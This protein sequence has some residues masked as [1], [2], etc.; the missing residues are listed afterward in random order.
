MRNRFLI[1]VPTLSFLFAQPSFSSI[2]IATNADR[3]A[4]VYAID[5]D[6]DGDIDVLMAATADNEIAWYENNGSE[7][8]TKHSITTS[9]TEARD[10][11]AIDLDRD[12]DMD[13]LSASQGSNAGIAWYENNGSESFTKRNITVNTEYAQ[14]VFAIDLDSDGDIDVLSA[15]ITDDKIEW[16]KNNGSQSFEALTITTNADGAYSVYAADVDSDGDMDVLSASVVDDEIAWYKNDG[17]EAFTKHTITDQADVPRSVYAID[18]DQDGD[19]DVL[20]ASEDDNKIA[21]YENNGSQSFTSHTISSSYEDPYDVIALDLDQDGD[22]D[23]LSANYSGAN[24]VWFEN[25]GSESFTPHVINA[26]VGSD[27]QSIFAAD[28]NQD[29]QIDVLSTQA[30][31]DKVSWHKNTAAPFGKP[32]FQ[33]KQFYANNNIKKS[34]AIDMDKDG[35]IDI[36]TADYV[37]DKVSWHQNDGSENFTDYTVA[38][39]ID[40]AND[41]IALD[42][43]QDGDMDIISSSFTDD[44]VR[45]YENNGSQDFTS[46][47]VVNNA[48]GVKAIATGDLDQDGDIDL[49]SVSAYD[50]Q[51]SWYENTDNFMTPNKRS[52]ANSSQVDYPT[53]VFLADMDIDGDLDILIASHEKAE[54]LWIENKGLQ[55]NG[56]LNTAYHSIYNSFTNVSSAKAIDLDLDGDMDVVGISYQKLIWFENNGFMSFTSR[57]ITSLSGN[58]AFFDLA[59]ID[60]DGFIDIMTGDWAGSLMWFKNDGS[61]N[62]SSEWS[63]SVGNLYDVFL[64]DLD[65]DGDIDIIPSNNSSPANWY[66]SNPDRDSPTISSVS[67]ASDNSTVS[68]TMDEAVFRTTGGSGDLEAGDF[69]LSIAG[70]VATVAAVP[71]GISIS[72]NVST[73]E[74]DLTGTPNGSEVLTVNPVD[75]GIYDANGNEASTTQSNNTVTLNDQ[76]VP[77]ISSV[78][79]ASDNSTVSVTMSEAVFNTTGGSGTLEVSDFAFSLRGGTATLSSA[80]PTSISVRG[81]T[82]FTLGISFSGTPNGTDTLT[83]TPVDNNS[84]YDATGNGAITTQSNNLGILNVIGQ[85]TGNDLSV[86]ASKI[87]ISKLE[88]SNTGTITDL[89]I[90]LTIDMSDNSAFQ[91]M[92]VSLLSPTGT[93]VKLLKYGTLSSDTY[94]TKLDDEASQSITEAQTPYSGRYRPINPISNFYNET[95]KGTWELV[96]A[97][98]QSHTGTI[99]WVLDFAT[100]T[101]TPLSILNYGTE[102]QGEQLAIAANGN[103]TKSLSISD[104]IIITDLNIKLT[105]NMSDNTAYQY[106]RVLLKS[107]KISFYPFIESQFENDLYKTIIDDEAVKVRASSDDWF[108]PYIGPHQSPYDTLSRFNGTSTS[109][110]W[111]VIVTNSQGYTGTLDWSLLVNSSLSRPTLQLTSTE[112]ATTSNPSIPLTATFDQNVKG[113]EAN[114]IEVTGGTIANFSGS[115]KTYTFSIIPTI[116]I[117]N[118]IVNIPENVAANRASYGNTYSWGTNKLTFDY[119]KKAR[120]YFV[121]KTGSDSNSG[122][123]NKPLLTIQ[124]AIDQSYHGDTVLVYPGKYE[125]AIDF[126]KMNIVLASRYLTTNDSTYRDSTIIQGTVTMDTLDSRTEFVGFMI[127]KNYVFVNGGSPILKRLHIRENQAD[128]ASL[129]IRGGANLSVNDIEIKKTDGSGNYDGGIYIDNSR[130]VLNNAIVDSNKTQYGGGISSLRSHITINN[131]QF[132]DNTA[133][134]GGGIYSSYDS[135]YTMTNVTVARDSTSTAGGGLFFSEALTPVVLTNVTID[136]NISD[137]GDGGGIHANQLS[138][139]ITNSSI[140][141]NTTK[142]TY[143]GGLYYTMSRNYAD[144]DSFIVD[145]TS[146]I[147]N[148]SYNDGGGANVNIHDYGKAIFTNALFAKNKAGESVYDKVSALNIYTATNASSKVMNSTFVSNVGS[149]SVIQSGDGTREFINS[150]SWHNTISTTSPNVNGEYIQYSNIEGGLS[151]LPVFSEGNLNT[152]P[153]FADY[154]NGNY[155]LDDSSPS[156]GTGTAVGAP[157]TDIEGNIRP[158]PA[159]SN[160][161]MGAYESSKSER[162]SGQN[163][164]VL[165][166]GNDLNSGN[167]N[168]PFLTIQRGIDRA[169]NGDTVLVYPGKY[170]EPVNFKKK[171]IVL[172]SRYLTTNDSTYIESTVIQAKVTMDTLDNTA[173]LIGFMI[174]KDQV[175]VNGGSPKLKRLHLRGKA[176]GQALHIIGGAN[177]SINDLNVKKNGNVN[178]PSNNAGIYVEDSRVIFNNVV[179]DSNYIQGSGGGMHSRRSHI[180]INNSQ[181]NDNFADYGGGI[182]SEVDSSLK[183]T[184]VTVARDS[185]TGGG[186]AL[187]VTETLNPVILNNVTIDNNRSSGGHGGGIYANQISLKISKSYITNNKTIG[188]YGGGLY[189]TMSRNYT[190]QDSLIVDNT[191]FIGNRSYHDGGGANVN[192]GDYGKAVFTNVLFAKNKAGE[193]TFDKVPGIKSDMS[194]NGELR[195]INN[196]FVDN[197]GIETMHHD[198]S[199]GTVINTIAWHN[200]KTNTPSGFVFLYS[201]IQDISGS[202]NSGNINLDPQ[203]VDLANGDYSLKSTSPS[204]DAGHPDLDG[205]GVTWESDTDDQDPDGTRMDMGSAWFSQY[206]SEPPTIQITSIE[207]DTKFG[208][209]TSQT[210]EWNA[211][212]NFRIDWTKLY[213]KAPDST[214]YTF[215]DSLPGNPGTY[216]YLAPLKVSKDYYMKISVGD[217]SGNIGSA[218]EK[219]EVIDATLP[220][221]TLVKPSA[222][223]QVLEYDTLNIEW[224]ITDNHLLDSTWIYYSVDSL[225]NL[226]P[227]DTLKFDSLSYK[228]KIP[229]GVTKKAQIKIVATDSTG[230]VGSDQSA[231][232]EVVDNTKPTIQITSIGDDTKFGSGTSQTIEWNATDSSG[233]DWTKLYL[234]PPDSTNYTLLDNL[235]GNPGTYDYL[236]PLK[237]SKDYYM[238]ISVGDPLGN[239]AADTQRFEVIDATLPVVTLVKPNASTQVLEYDTLNIEWTIADNHLLDSTWIYYSVDSLV[240]IIAV[241][242]L[243]FDSLSYKFK[244]PEGVTKKAQI[245]IVVTDSTGNVGNGQSAVFEVV[246]NTK[247][248]IAWNELSDKILK[249]GKSVG[250]GWTSSDNVG[251]VKVDIAYSKDQSIWIEVANQIANQNNFNWEIQNDP[252]T[253][254]QFRIIGFDAVALSDTSIMS[255]FTIKESYPQITST[256]NANI[257]NWK[258]KEITLFFD[259]SLDVNSINTSNFSLSSKQNDA[260]VP[261][262]NYDEN[263]K[264]I[265]LTFDNGFISRDSLGITVSGDI[266]SKYGYLF[267]GDA[268]E[269]PGGNYAFTFQS[270]LLGDYNDDTKID[271]ID[272]AVLLNALQSNNIENELGPVEGSTAPYF[273]TITDGNID[274][275]DVM[276]FVMVWNWNK[277][278][279]NGSAN[280]WITSGQ[281]VDISFLHDNIILNTIDEAFLYELEIKFISGQFEVVSNQ[282]PSALLKYYDKVSN[283]VYLT[284]EIDQ[285]EIR[286]PFKFADRY[287][288]VQLSYRLLD[289]TGNSISQGSVLETIENVPD[290][291]ALHENYPNPFN[292]ITTINYDLPQQTHVKLVIYDMLGREVKELINQEMSA[293]Y[294]SISWNT[295]NNYGERVSGGIY[296]YQIQTKDFVK[297]RKMVLLK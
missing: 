3:A 283:T 215:L 187:Y 41:V 252:S 233:I 8:F 222:N 110:T 124:K 75:D 11:I 111:Q 154:L 108:S 188:N 193:G 63:T 213:L 228:F 261:S 231:V 269:T 206:E 16:Y 33:K 254:I 191:S 54:I 100:S 200:T 166:T 79:I 181:F 268:D 282:L 160:P 256:D 221:V 101:L 190:D 220:V 56:N 43:D 210:I 57:Q 173:A 217:P 202:S 138:I 2:D 26:T 255:G 21:W 291:F 65:L 139:K 69:T 133:Y 127:Y 93:V 129:Y 149:S 37:E 172:A 143:G 234:K 51:V 62:F 164:Y 284:S 131:S 242:T 119:T 294:R 174:Y 146:F 184:N 86:D 88:I 142:G 216:D 59:D 249:I 122:E 162:T 273:R 211:T 288:T 15:S 272:L 32:K 80:T 251:V 47:G 169:Y 42:L 103:S 224:T 279:P 126:K 232:F 179:S 176:N 27:A 204:I 13:V 55:S 128:S 196:T 109:D 163:Y 264:S 61:Q 248:T 7:S 29:G 271:G 150:I 44:Y 281:E 170:E 91:Y 237:V 48:D 180:T 209:G 201:N 177:L 292:P 141:N 85:Y 167:F 12:G 19:I 92:N 168:N 286:I 250:L 194:S 50:D 197:T 64:I 243:K 90:L 84:I 229:E 185:A 159:G 17:S 28:I 285:D 186:P 34:I 290:Q 77:T 158:N 30:N 253:T 195:I 95:I 9:A 113:F 67:I 156:L 116:G 78:S 71:L 18:L 140:T 208:S 117:G 31:T 76:L 114:D 10:V 165:K 66:S 125:E 40:G 20:S 205:D 70:G 236:A 82:T 265:I 94:E 74:L 218:T 178:A 280:E 223:I 136:N 157:S 6:N 235:P 137:G 81:D 199:I 183:M 68:V 24:S 49:V 99:K 98:K 225:V 189:Y 23:V 227:V 198:G 212:D 277:Q 219:F 240:N 45:W 72:G 36:I 115:E 35:D 192:I 262:F 39:N 144:Q 147:G 155:K 244:I 46:H 135:S 102:F 89:D 274:I 106:I 121:S 120:S 105:L 175:L 263:T 182:Y 295:K 148:R 58:S 276:A 60:S 266:K 152:D 203:F 214:D 132:N 118:V 238:K 104:D 52:L 241:D 247:P 230:N 53:S 38:L 134:S 270:S 278:N 123:L 96:V 130:L 293:G 297:T 239:I 259:Q 275:E 83:V 245:K 161:D 260:Q 207:D 5:M 112:S 145:N 246:D 267:D 73:L 151:G 4:A 14:S 153:A 87:S 257:I 25:N 97:N 289:E 296:F 171:N 226:I 22:I 107:D 1:L 287:G 258:T